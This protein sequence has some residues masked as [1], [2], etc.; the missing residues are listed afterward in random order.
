MTQP[1]ELSLPAAVRSWLDDYLP[2]GLSAI[3]PVAHRSQHRL[4]RLEVAG[5]SL[6]L[7]LHRN[8]PAYRSELH[9][10]R[11]WRWRS[12][13]F[14][15]VVAHPRTDEWRGLLLTVLPGTNAEQAAL[16]GF[17]RQQVWREAGAAA[18]RFQAQAEGEW[19]GCADEVG[20]PLGASW[21]DPVEYAR[22]RLQE[23]AA[24][25]RSPG[26]LLPHERAAC[27]WAETHCEVFA[28][29]RPRP[30]LQDDAPGNWLVQGG[31][32]TGK[33]DFEEARW[34]LRVEGFSQL[35]ARYGIAEA[36]GLAAFLAGFGETFPEDQWRHAI[37][38]TAIANLARGVEL[39]SARHT[40]RGRRM[41]AQLSRWE[42]VPRSHPAG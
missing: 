26:L 14:A 39:N 23:V 9:V 5:G 36:D 40:R 19:F 2:A 13:L 18:A 1:R 10:Y 17:E 3:T 31:H 22:Y 29:E 32:L 8:E 37:I 35:W 38:R 42:S 28:G 27:D 33:V 24:V 41:L 12:G 15:D 6:F 34:G 16:S 30:V 25:V 4:F 20:R 21:V 11:H 7:K